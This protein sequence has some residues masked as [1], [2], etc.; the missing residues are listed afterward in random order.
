MRSAMADAG[1]GPD[2]VEYVCA[3]GTGTPSND[4]TETQAI[5]AALGSAADRTPV[6]SIKSMLGHTCWSAPVRLPGVSATSPVVPSPGVTHNS[7][8][9]SEMLNLMVISA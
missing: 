8:L 3:H 4:R 5:R 1:V 7:A 6:S 2:E 9:G